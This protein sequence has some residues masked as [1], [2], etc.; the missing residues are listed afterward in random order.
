MLPCVGEDD[1]P[2][3][4]DN[5]IDKIRYAVWV[6]AAKFPSVFAPLAGRILVC[7]LVRAVWCVCRSLAWRSAFVNPLFSDFAVVFLSERQDPFTLFGGEGSVGRQMIIVEQQ[8]TQL[9]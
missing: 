2:R 4:A 6:L 9:V 1:L 7:G 5:S 3:K 8:R